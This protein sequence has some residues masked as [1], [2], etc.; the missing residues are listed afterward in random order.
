ME[1]EQDKPPLTPELCQQI[2]VQSTPDP[3]SFKPGSDPSKVTLFD[4][5][6]CSSTESTIFVKAVMNRLRPWKIN[7]S[8]VG[9]APATTVQ[10]SADSIN[11]NAF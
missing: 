10:Q 6:V 3:K 2:V 5:G 11:D 8:A 4:L 1:P 9:S 7:S